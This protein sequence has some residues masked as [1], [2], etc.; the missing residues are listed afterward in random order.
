M[1][2]ICR[3]YARTERNA[4]ADS[5]RDSAIAETDGWGALAADGDTIIASK[6]YVDAM[7]ATK[8]NKLNSGDGGNITVSGTGNVVTGITASNGAVTVTKGTIAATDY[9]KNGTN[10]LNLTMATGESKDS[11]APSITAIEGMKQGAVSGTASAWSTTSG[12]GADDNKV[13]TTKAI[14]QQLDLIRTAITSGDSTIT[15]QFEAGMNARTY[16]MY[17]AWVEGEMPK[18]GRLYNDLINAIAEDTTYHNVV[19]D[20]SHPDRIPFNANIQKGILYMEGDGIARMTDNADPIAEKSWSEA[21]GLD[22]SI[23]TIRDAKNFDKFV[24]TVAAVEARVMKAQAD[25]ISAAGNNVIS[26]S[27]NV[28]TSHDNNTTGANGNHNDDKLTTV[29]AIA[30]TTTR[31]A[32][33]APTAS[34]GKWASSSASDVNVPTVKAVAQQIEALDNASEATDSNNTYH[35]PIVAVS[36][37]DGIVTATRG[38][39]SYQDA[40]ENALKDVNNAANNQTCN[41]ANPCV[42][43]YIGTQA[44]GV[45]EFRWT[46]MDTEGVNAG[47]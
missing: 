19:A 35:T 25:A 26:E 29:A 20:I 7:D 44:S 2:N 47:V 14:T 16:A 11:M 30:A 5:D 46:Q 21:R 34:S 40:M 12:D 27:N 39:I 8:Q 10:A 9:I 32:S 42:L 3:N 18:E 28:L 43:T 38:T 22:D 36:E 23:K 41:A 31:A 24:P 37:A 33:T 45:P 17:N 4:K 15:N 13:P 6:A 1:R